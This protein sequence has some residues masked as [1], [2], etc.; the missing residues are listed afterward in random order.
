MLLDIKVCKAKWVQSLKSRSMEMIFHQIFSYIL[1]KNEINKI[2][3]EKQWQGR[4]FVHNR[5]SRKCRWLVPLVVELE[6]LLIYIKFLRVFFRM[7]D[8]ILKYFLLHII[9]NFDY[10]T[11]GK[12][13]LSINRYIC[14]YDIDVFI[15][16]FSKR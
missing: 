8:W 15:Q 4:I 9:D 16:R 5:V 1:N 11:K 7:C 12:I 6:Q 13:D 14:I 2:S 10:F 3:E